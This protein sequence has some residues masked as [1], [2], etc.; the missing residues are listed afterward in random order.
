MSV[1]VL[2]AAM[3]RDGCATPPPRCRRAT[4]PR[5]LRTGP[6]ELLLEDDEILVMHLISGGAFALDNIAR[7]EAG[8]TTTA[9]LRAFLALKLQV[10]P[11]QVY[12]L[13]GLRLLSDCDPIF[14][15]TL[16]V[17]V[18]PGDPEERED[19]LPRRLRL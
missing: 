17:A 1:P 6:G 15:S 7:R 10:M 13:D 3:S 9:E 11:Y 12:L 19:M 5:V 16:T 18:V 14:S 4:P 2:G 8:T